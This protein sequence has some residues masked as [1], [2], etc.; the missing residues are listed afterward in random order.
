MVSH[1]EINLPC[2]IKT[3]WRF[4]ARFRGVVTTSIFWLFLWTLM[5]VS[6]LSYFCS[7]SSQQFQDDLLI[8]GKVQWRKH[9]GPNAWL[10]LFFFCLCVLTHYFQLCMTFSKE[11]SVIESLQHLPSA[12]ITGFFFSSRHHFFV[13]S[14][15]ELMFLDIYCLYFSDII[16]WVLKFNW[17]K[18]VKWSRSI[19]C[20]YTGLTFMFYKL[21]LNI[22]DAI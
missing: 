12:S 5:A 13:I 1:C 22:Y 6:W 3:V 18:N 8:S 10:A 21:S 2:R 14:Q 9:R 17:F 19:K 11:M 4:Y 7:L 16:V 15:S 20:S